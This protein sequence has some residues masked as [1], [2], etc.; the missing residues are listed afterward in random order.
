MFPNQNTPHQSRLYDG[1]RDRNPNATA[2]REMRLMHLCMN[3][4]SLVRASRLTRRKARL[5]PLICLNAMAAK[6]LAAHTRALYYP[7]FYI[8]RV[9][10][11]FRVYTLAC[12]VT[13]RVKRY[14]FQKTRNLRTHTRGRS[15]RNK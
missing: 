9:A 15:E 10:E 1:K 11:R 12:A 13:T 6:N 5:C 3:G 7:Y 2:K 14:T 4:S 8:R